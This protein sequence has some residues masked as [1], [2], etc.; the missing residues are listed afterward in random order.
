MDLLSR[1]CKRRSH[2]DANTGMRIEEQESQGRGPLWACTCNIFACN[3]KLQKR[4]SIPELQKEPEKAAQK[5]DRHETIAAFALFVGATFITAGSALAQDHAAKATVP[6]NFTV[7]GSW[8]PAGNYTIESDSTSANI[9]NITDREKSVHILALGLTDPNYQGQ[10]SKLVF[11]KYGD[12]YFLSEI[13]YANSSTKVDFPVSKAE[14]NAKVQ[15]Q[16]AGLRINND[17][18][19]ALK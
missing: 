13:C 18:M 2:L 6:F 19:I 3:N 8:L 14:K 1:K 16:E 15:A 5:G 4:E 7:N 9:F 17:L 11:H 12:Q 10:S